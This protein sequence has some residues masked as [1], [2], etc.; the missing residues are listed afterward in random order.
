MLKRALLVSV[1][2]LASVLALTACDPAKFLGPIAVQLQTDELA[3]AVCE[4][5]NADII[6]NLAQ[7]G[8]ST[9]RRWRTLVDAEGDASMVEGQAFTSTML[10]EGMVVK[11]ELPLL[12]DEESKI[13]VYIRGLQGGKQLNWENEVS[14]RQLQSAGESWVQSDGSVTKDAC[15]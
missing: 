6:I 15:G 2:G 13:S 14:W 9:D 11:E 8:P 1:V 7:S 4:P 10:P 3:V 5:I 12:L